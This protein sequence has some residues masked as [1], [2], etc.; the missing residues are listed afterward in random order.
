MLT[1]LRAHTSEYDLRDVRYRLYGGGHHAF[2]IPPRDSVTFW[3]RSCLYLDVNGSGIV[4]DPVFDARY[5]PLSLRLIGHPDVEHYRGAELILV[6]HAHADHLSPGTLASFPPGATVLCPPRVAKYLRG[7][8]LESRTLLPWDSYQGENLKVTA[9]PACH[10]GGRY[11]VRQRGD[12]GAIGFVIES[13]LGN[14]YYSGDTSYFDGF[15]EIGD[16]FSPDVS[17]LNVNIHLPGRMAL[18]AVR[19]LGTGKVVPAH[20]GAYLSP[21]SP[22]AARWREQLLSGFEEGYCELPVG[23]S[24]CLGTEH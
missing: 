3:G 15:L 4:T 13:E 24:L 12:G 1:G 16:R 2:G 23:G 19:D 9:V 8:P 6:S 14:V 21:A 7:L 17:I 22:A 18:R 5:S 11:S 20:H 10:A